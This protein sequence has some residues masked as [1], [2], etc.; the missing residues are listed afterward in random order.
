MSQGNPSLKD[1]ELERII[2]AIRE[3][4]P[5]MQ[6][7]AGTLSPAEQE[8]LDTQRH[9]R[10]CMTE[11]NSGARVADDRFCVDCGARGVWGRRCDSCE[12]GRNEHSDCAWGQQ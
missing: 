4:F 3:I 5:L 11:W 7:L 1:P 6:E 8:I 10:V 9:E 2:E 12:R